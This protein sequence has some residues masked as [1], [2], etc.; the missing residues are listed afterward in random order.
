MSA[1]RPRR[2]APNSRPITAAVWIVR[3]RVS[4]SR[5]IRAMMTPC[6]VS[7]TSC[8]VTGRARTYP[9]SARARMPVSTKERVISS[10]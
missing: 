4:A 10:R 6:T 2:C 3:F 8:G 7:G 1:I 5:S 9:P